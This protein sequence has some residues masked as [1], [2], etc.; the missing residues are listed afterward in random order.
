V[1]EKPTVYVLING[2]PEGS[3][4]LGVF[5]TREKAEAAQREHNAKVQKDHEEFVA[6]NPD[7]ADPC[8]DIMDDWDAANAIV[9]YV[10]DSYRDADD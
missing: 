10:L 1:S 5:S 4:F 9:E 7:L 8:R 3:N 2:N 6:R